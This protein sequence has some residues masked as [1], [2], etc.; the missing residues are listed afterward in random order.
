MMATCFGSLQSHRQASSITCRYIRRHLKKSTTGY[1]F[2]VILKVAWRWLRNWDGISS[3]CD[4]KYIHCGDS[5]MP[6]FDICHLHTVGWPKDSCIW[7]W[8]HKTRCMFFYWTWIMKMQMYDG[9]LHWTSW[10]WLQKHCISD[11]GSVSVIRWKQQVTH[12]GPLGEDKQSDSLLISPDGGQTASLQD[13]LILWLKQE[14]EQEL[15][16]SDDSCNCIFL[17]TYVSSFTALKL[18]C[19]EWWLYIAYALWHS[20]MA[21]TNQ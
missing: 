14:N 7:N 1:H 12:L 19:S 20:L 6:L 2:H 18:W 13:L 16:I 9:H 15:N 21:P 10:F 4:I 5:D 8:L 3:R 17:L 11:T